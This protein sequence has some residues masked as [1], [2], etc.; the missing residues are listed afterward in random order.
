MYITASTSAA[1]SPRRKLNRHASRS[2]LHDGQQSG[3]ET[4]KKRRQPKKEVPDNKS[5]TTSS[6]SSCLPGF[7]AATSLT[8]SR[9]SPAVATSLDVK[10][11]GRASDS[12]GRPAIDQKESNVLTMD[13]DLSNDLLQS[14]AVYGN[15]TTPITPSLVSNT[16][17]DKE[18]TSPQDSAASSTDEL[19]YSPSPT[20]SPRVIPQKKMAVRD[21]SV[22]PKSSPFKAPLTGFHFLAARNLAVEERSFT[23]VVKPNAEGLGIAGTGLENMPVLQ[24]PA[25]APPA[26]VQE[27]RSAPL[28]PAKKR[29]TSSPLTWSSDHKV[30]DA[31][32]LGSPTLGS[33]IETE[34][35]QELAR[36][37]ITKA[38]FSVSQ[39]TILQELAKRKAQSK[40]SMQQ[41]S[42]AQYTP[43]SLR[44]PEEITEK[45]KEQEE[46]SKTGPEDGV[47]RKDMAV[48]QSQRLSPRSNM[49]STLNGSLDMPAPSSA[50]DRSPLPG[51]GTTSATA[52]IEDDIDDGAS[53][54]SIT[55]HLMHSVV[56]DADSAGGWEALDA[57]YSTKD[58]AR[59]RLQS[60]IYELNKRH[61][62]SETVIS[63]RQEMLLAI[64]KR[65]NLMLKNWAPDFQ[66]NLETFG[67]TKYGLDTDSSDLDLCIVDP[68][69][70]D[71]FRD[72]RD[73]YDLTVSDNG[74][75]E[76][77]A[78][79]E[80]D[81]EHSTSTPFSRHKKNNKEW[82]KPE[83]R[84]RMS[85][86]NIYDVQRLADTLRRMGHQQVIAIPN[87]IVPI[88]KFKSR[89]GIKADMVSYS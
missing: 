3:S 19:P 84:K 46:I 82:T 24:H 37:A 29:I 21:S 18:G 83:T 71:G 22:T 76:A 68:Y 1:D 62:P 15:D 70:P 59:H 61:R 35:S 5:T 25:T 55:S 54:A 23:A 16:V 4:S 50:L 40:A 27:N 89:A 41:T 6:S 75:R 64:R 48:P 31:P 51:D 20:V 14:G 56:R 43:P 30:F 69:R 81:E 13:V 57:S 52:D 60:A 11:K 7:V 58:K 42:E 17:S 88:V 53:D 63:A 47:K 36:N 80:E 49:A 65:L 79:T 85:L 8:S 2:S 33:M 86:A 74:V 72:V 10:G 28:D 12:D 87:A 73:L 44:Q 77:I 9:Q 34:D 66:Y 26:T 38:A 78:S 67:S 45:Q 39:A 32:T